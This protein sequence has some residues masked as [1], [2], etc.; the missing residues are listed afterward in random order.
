VTIASLTFQSAVELASIGD[1]QA[2]MWHEEA[3]D[4]SEA[5]P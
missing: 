3:A 5:L 2:R 1:L 4:F